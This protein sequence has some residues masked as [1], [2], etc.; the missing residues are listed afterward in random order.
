MKLL[1]AT[2]IYPPQI[3]GPATYAKNL[4]EAFSSLGHKVFVKKYGF[5]NFL[6]SGI[7]H[8]WFFI[9]S[10]SPVFQSDFCLALDTFSVGAPIVLASKI[11][12]KKVILRIGGDFLW[13]SYLN[14]TGETILFSEFYDVARGKLNLKEK[15]IFE[16]SKWVLRNTDMIVFSTNWQKEIFIKNYFLDREKVSVVENFYGA[17]EPNAFSEKGKKIFVSGVRNLKWKRGFLDSAF[18]LASKNDNSLVLDKETCDYDCF[19]NKI[20]KCYA[21]ILVSLADI[22]PNTILDA[23]RCNK[24][25]ILTKE[26]GLD[27]IRD[28]A[29]L[30]DPRDENDIKEKILWLADEKNYMYQKAKIEKFDFVHS[31]EDIAKEFITIFNKIK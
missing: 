2:G 5:E 21:V 28:L 29:I 11:F 12:N 17:K 16:V 3:G 9:K 18:A 31:W 27:R 1:I 24:P 13:E 4:K 14:R 25:F 7:R 26:N 22:S 15:I 10:L 8:F 23:L 6:P 19:F 30:V 20:K